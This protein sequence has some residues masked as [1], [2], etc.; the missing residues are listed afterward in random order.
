MASNGVRVK[1]WSVRV[2]GI[3]GSMRIR[4]RE[5]VFAVSA[6]TSNGGQSQKPYLQNV[7]LTEDLSHTRRFPHKRERGFQWCEN[8]AKC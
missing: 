3:K 7:S 8:I 4:E 2:M 6:V 1:S 5:G